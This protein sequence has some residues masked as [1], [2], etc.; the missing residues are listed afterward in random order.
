VKERGDTGKRGP[1][2]ITTFDL[3]QDQLCGIEVPL[4][5]FAAST[6]PFEAAYWEKLLDLVTQLQSNDCENEIHG[7]IL[8]NELTLCERDPRKSEVRVSVRVDWQ[9]YAPLQDGFPEMHYRLQVSRPEKT[10]TE[11]SRTVDPN[12]AARIIC[13]AFGFDF[14]NA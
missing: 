10:L 5:R 7:H 8:F 2:R 14:R 11:D 13:R 12:A 1:M 6:E 9:D 4:R 3:D